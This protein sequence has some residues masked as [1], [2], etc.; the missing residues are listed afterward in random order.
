MCKIK[1]S[2][3]TSFLTCQQ[4]GIIL[5]CL[6]MWYSGPYDLLFLGGLPSRV[7]NSV[8]IKMQA[9]HPEYCQQLL[10]F[11]MK[12]PRVDVLHEHGNGNYRMSYLPNNCTSSV[13]LPSPSTL[14]TCAMRAMLFALTTR[15]SLWPS[16]RRE[17]KDTNS[18]TSTY[19][20]LDYC[21]TAGVKN[22]PSSMDPLTLCVHWVVLLT[23]ARKGCTSFPH[24][25]LFLPLASHS[26]LSY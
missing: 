26:L 15:N 22:G 17:R 11:W 20:E 9:L 14:I 4:I 1:Y 8:S 19:G 13:S 3:K 21:D 12:V 16:S 23:M 2:S 25:H 18:P 6:T 5:K 10:I 24:P 7:L